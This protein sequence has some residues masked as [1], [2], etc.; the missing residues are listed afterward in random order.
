M[1][2]FSMFFAGQS[3]AEI[4]EEFV[5]SIRFKDAEGKPVPWKL[6]SITE[7]ENQECRRAATRKVKGKNGV[8]TP[9]IDPNDYMAKLMVTSVIYP[10]LKNSELQKS[11]GV[12]GAESLLRKMLLPGEF[13]A[14]GERVQALN[15]FDRDMNELVDEVKN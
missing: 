13:A 10:D 11:Y 15:G 14:L 4:T 9:E 3:P 8:Y 5:V 2:D 1:S 6:R 12:L 7:E